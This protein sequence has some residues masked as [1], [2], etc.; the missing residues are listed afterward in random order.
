MESG[1]IKVGDKVDIIELESMKSEPTVPKQYVSQVLDFASQDRIMISA[2]LEGGRIIPLEIGEKYRF[3]FYTKKGMYECKGEI[4]ERYKD[5][6]IHMMEV[7]FLSELEKNQRREYFRFEY[8][9]DFKYCYLEIS[10]NEHA[11]QQ[12]EIDETTWMKGTLTDISGGGMRFVSSYHHEKNDD[13]FVRLS[14]VTKGKSFT[15][16]TKGKIKSSLEL[17]NRPKFYQNRVEFYDIN[18]EERE[19]IIKFIFEEQRKIIRREKGLT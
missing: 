11:E 3:Y 16:Q 13:L 7:G 14:F 15:C 2:P 8:I 6:N 9:L 1:L 12:G 18:L 5:D 19:K 17:A 4:K 10:E